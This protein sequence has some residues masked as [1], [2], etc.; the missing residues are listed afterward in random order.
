MNILQ[1]I[2]IVAL[3]AFVSG[4][5]AGHH[6]KTV[7][8]NA[9]IVEQVK[10][11][12]KIDA[13]NEVQVEKQDDSDKLKISQLQQDLAA[14]KLAAAAH[15]SVPKPL[16]TKCVSSSKEDTGASQATS[17]DREPAGSYEAAYRTL[18]VELL[19]VGAV[20]EQL[21]LQVLSC[22]AQWPR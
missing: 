6:Q 8:D 16:T 15:R 17:A 3:L 19:D 14:A 7:S 2:G 5:A 11:V 9:A 4:Y 1:I 12:A 13:K 21:R 22:Q 10:H 20:A 18:R